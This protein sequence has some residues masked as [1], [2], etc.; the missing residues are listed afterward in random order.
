MQLFIKSISGRT[1]TIEIDTDDYVFYLKQRMKDVGI[2]TFPPTDIR[3]IF[4]GKQ[5]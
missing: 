3:L 5:L 4:G 1:Y 2:T